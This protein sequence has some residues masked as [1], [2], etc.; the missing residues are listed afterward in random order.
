MFRF[1]L[2]YFLSIKCH[3]AVNNALHKFP[4]SDIMPS[5]WLTAT[6]W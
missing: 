6:C 5:N 4:E 2:E 1:I 3:K